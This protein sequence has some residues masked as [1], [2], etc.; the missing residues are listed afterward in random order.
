MNEAISFIWY[1]S[2]GSV[3]SV[4]Q[5]YLSINWLTIRSNQIDRVSKLQINLICFRPFWQDSST[6]LQG[7][8]EELP[9]SEVEWKIL[10]WSGEQSSMK[11]KCEKLSLQQANESAGELEL[12]FCCFSSLFAIKVKTA[13]QSNN[14]PLVSPSVADKNNEKNKKEKTRKIY[15]YLLVFHANATLLLDN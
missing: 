14:V 6:I 10:E 7:S 15:Y 1:P 4:S 2:Y 12:S 9:R 8:W 13:K 5:T 3:I 11:M